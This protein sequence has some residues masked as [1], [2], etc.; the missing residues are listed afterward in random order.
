VDAHSFRIAAFRHH[1][2][3]QR[4]RKRESMKEEYGDDTMKN[5]TCIECNMQAS[6]NFSAD[7]CSMQQ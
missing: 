5:T 7:Q 4:E 1:S 3:E 6:T 2:I